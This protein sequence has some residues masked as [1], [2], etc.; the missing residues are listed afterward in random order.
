MTTT[1]IFNI[2]AFMGSISL[3]RVLPALLIFLICYAAI[4]ILTRLISKAL[5]KSRMDSTLRG[6]A[7][8]AVKALLWVLAIIIVAES[9][10]INTASLV[11]L[12][13]VAGLALSLALQNIMSN[14]FSGVTLLITR[15]FSAGDYVSVG[16]NEGSVQSVGLFYTVVDTVDNKRVSI[17]NSDVTAAALVNY[18]TEPIRRVDMSFSVDFEAEPE[19]VR[20]AMLEAAAEDSR[21]L[22][23]PAPAVYVA[24]YKEGAVEYSL[25]LWCKNEDYWGIYFAM[26][27]SVRKSLKSHG[28][29]MS[30]A[31]VNVHVMR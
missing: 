27:E 28:I 23:E 26:N 1:E 14:I 25:R 13:S 15:P 17:P 4:R 19:N 30:C 9:L 2:N 29:A 24:A 7:L 18:S 11:A 6:F 22:R 8:T 5:K 3:A 10:G 21:V 20:A 12:V 31:H 16:G